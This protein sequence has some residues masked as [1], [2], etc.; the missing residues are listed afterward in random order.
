MTK[1]F[2]YPLKSLYISY[3]E[4]WIWKKKKRILN[5]NEHTLGNSSYIHYIQ[6]IFYLWLEFEARWTNI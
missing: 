2:L 1:S 4:F 6:N 5:L 3:E